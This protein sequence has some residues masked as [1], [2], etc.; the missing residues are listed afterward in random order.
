MSYF[1][2][3]TSCVINDDAD[4]DDDD[5]DNFCGLFYLLMCTRISCKVK[6]SHL[7]CINYWHS[8]ERVGTCGHTSAT[9]GLG[10]CRNLDNFS[11]WLGG[12]ATHLQS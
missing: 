2:A 6:S 1:F 10:I 9:T 7:Q 3:I 5:D 8:H 4:D 12:G 11:G